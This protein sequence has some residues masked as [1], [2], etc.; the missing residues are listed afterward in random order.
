V[1]FLRE[2]PPADQDPENTLHPL[3]LQLT[4]LQPKQAPTMLQLGEVEQYRM[5]PGTRPV[6]PQASLGPKN[7]QPI[8]GRPRKYSMSFTTG[9]LMYQGSVSL[10]QLYLDI[11]NWEEVGKEVSSKNILQVNT[12]RSSQRLLREIRSRLQGLHNSEL[13]LLVMGSVEEQRH[14]L[15]IS[16]CRR[17]HLIAD[18]ALEV[19]RE[20]FICLN[21]YLSYEDFDVFLYKK[22]EWQAELEH[23]K[24]TT[25]KKARQVLFKMLREVKLLSNENLIL[26]AI[27]SNQ[28]L[29]AVPREC[30]GDLLFFPVFESDLRKWAQ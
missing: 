23:V 3:E 2:V 29:R 24:A 22:L 19:I 16:I 14:V 25:R 11:K 12:S 9:S 18:F 8:R 28:L 5:N 6:E 15:W 4:V 20:K 10:A 21:N 17:Y 30:Y 7:E 13:N 27:F 26:P 1:S